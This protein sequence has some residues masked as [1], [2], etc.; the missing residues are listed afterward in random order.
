MVDSWAIHKLFRDYCWG[1]DYVDLELLGS[2]MTEDGTLEIEIKGADTVGPFPNRQAIL[3]FTRDVR[4][5]QGDARFH[6]FTNLGIEENGANIRA[7]VFAL[8]IKA[9]AGVVT[10]QT[11]GVYTADIVRDGESYRIRRMHL[12]LEAPF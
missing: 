7:T 9:A 10:L 8:I 5:G 12:I 1:V 2:V 6:V 3:D 4:A 11:A